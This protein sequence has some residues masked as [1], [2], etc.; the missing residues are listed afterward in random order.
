LETIGYLFDTQTPIYEI[1]TR[2]ALALVLS[3]ALGYEREAFKRTISPSGLSGP[4]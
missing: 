4:S 2:L 1:V 3:M